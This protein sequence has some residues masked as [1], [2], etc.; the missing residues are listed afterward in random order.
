MRTVD[1]GD[2]LNT[3]PREEKYLILPEGKV[4]YYCGALTMPKGY[5]GEVE[6]YEPKPGDQYKDIP[7]AF[8]YDP[9]KTKT[10]HANGIDQGE[11]RHFVH[12]IKAA[13]SL[14]ERERAVYYFD[15]AIKVQE[16][17]KNDTRGTEEE[18]P[19]G[20][21]EKERQQDQERGQRRL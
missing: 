5:P 10:L 13:V 15:Q 20:S 14:A 4:Y 16:A 18:A 19:S 1:Y 11:Y 8:V 3:A 6:V 12:A 2:L 17:R 21:E 9:A 7:A